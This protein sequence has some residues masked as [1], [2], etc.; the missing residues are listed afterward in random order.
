MSDKKLEIWGLL[1]DLEMGKL[2]VDYVNDHISRLV[3]GMIPLPD[4][5]EFAEWIDINCIRDGNI[6]WKYK[7][8]NFKKSYT[9][10]EI[11]GFFKSGTFPLKHKA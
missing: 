2:S 8:D 5:L 4:T 6:K 3:D 7:G 11:F 10:K 9:T 1:R